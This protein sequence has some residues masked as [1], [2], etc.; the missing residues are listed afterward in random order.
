MY[1]KITLTILSLLSA[2]AMAMTALPDG[3]Y[4]GKGEWKDQAGAKGDYTLTVKVAKNTLT[5]VYNFTGGSKT[6]IMEAPLDQNGFFPVNSGGKQVG[7]GYCFSVQC[8]YTIAIDQL[9]LEESLTFYQDHLYRTGSK[10]DGSGK[11]I[12]WEEATDLVK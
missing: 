7:S 1:A 6:F 12:A 10:T 2:S 8:H 3:S 9:T 11:T 4:S 5:S